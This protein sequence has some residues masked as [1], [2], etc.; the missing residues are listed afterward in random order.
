MKYKNFEHFGRLSF[1]ALSIALAAYAVLK[2]AT[3]IILPF[4]CAYV[5]AYGVR[6]ISRRLFEK[7]NISEAF[8]SGVIIV[9]AACAFAA[10]VWFG[11]AA[12]LGEVREA[13]VSLADSFTKE[14]GFADKITA[15]VSYVAKRFGAD[16]AQGK[17]GEWMSAALEA[18]TGAAAGASAS[19]ASGAPVFLVGVIFAVIVFFYFVFGKFHLSDAVSKLVAK[20][21]QIA[22]KDMFRAAAD[23]LGKLIR[24]YAVLLLVNFTLLSVGFFVLGSDSAFVFAFLC[25]LFDLLPV[26]GVGTFLVPYAV[27]QLVCE[28]YVRAL[29]ALLILAVV[30]IT[31]QSL[32]AKLL[33]KNAGIH[34]AFEILLVYAGLRLAG[35]AGMF[36]LPIAVN[37]I[38][39]ALNARKNRSKVD[40]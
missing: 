6:R 28:Q 25:A 19:A 14:G 18:V 27:Y 36:L 11:F 34:P 39:T 31:R 3:P 1:Y 26:I 15:F 29:G 40:K 37:I 12:L 9:A 35:V 23:A 5:A 16:D 13:F 8:W 38:F 7:T 24:V 10:I 30:S 33:G 17:V 20:K 22:V 2:Y 32:E 21:Y 4:V